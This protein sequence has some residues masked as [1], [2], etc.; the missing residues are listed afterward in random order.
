MK[1]FSEALSIFEDNSGSDELLNN[2]LNPHPIAARLMGDRVERLCLEYVQYT[3]HFDEGAETLFPDIDSKPRYR[4]YYEEF[5]PE[6]DAVAPVH[7]PFNTAMEDI[8]QLKLDRMAREFFKFNLDTDLGLAK[9]DLFCRSFDIS[10][11]EQT[12]ERTHAYPPDYH[13]YDELPIVKFDGY[14]PLS[15]EG[16]AAESRLQ[17]HTAH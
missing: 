15:V 10:A 12:L 17:K 3:K 8:F 4:A 9:F 16:I 5:R 11:G 1:Q 13:T 7:P 2:V 14:D 6:I